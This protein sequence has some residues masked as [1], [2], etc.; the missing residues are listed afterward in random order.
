MPAALLL[1]LVVIG[2]LP[3]VLG[4]GMGPAPAAIQVRTVALVPAAAPPAAEAPPPSSGAVDVAEPA[5]AAPAPPSPSR[6]SSAPA[7]AAE[8]RPLAPEPLP[9]ALTASA[10]GDPLPPSPP[11]PSVDPP[12]AVAEPAPAASAA[13]DAPLPIGVA[14]AE[15]VPAA[16]TASSPA[17]IVDSGEP[18]PVYATRFPPSQS[19]GYRLQRGLLSG[20]A[21]LDWSRGEPSDPGAQYRVQLLAR[22]AGLAVLTQ[23]SQG[24]FDASGLV[25][26]RFTDERLR[27]PVRAANFQRER[28][29]IT[30]SGPS[31]EYGWVS[32][33]QDRLSWM[34]QLPAIVDANPRLASEGQRIT[35]AVI[36][37]RGDA[38]VWAF[39][40]VAAERVDTPAGPVEALKF[41][42]EPR[43]PNDT[44]AEVWLDPARHHLPA[45]ARL[46]NPPDGEVF[47]LLRESP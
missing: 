12:L 10:P 31:I 24:G 15:A 6:L 3:T 41:I 1:H 25:P 42:R 27:G 4:R 32:G 16:A 9:V 29:L 7:P 38:A 34:I 8:P 43:K 11:P 19:I 13:P 14:V 22:A 47:E 33:V 20:N 35:L 30:F 17:W 2:G 5:P 23:V 40:F 21:V 18:L 44:Q 39:Q 36:G 26:R 46:G 28:G 45:R 37:A